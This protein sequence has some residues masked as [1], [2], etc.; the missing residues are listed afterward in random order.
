VKA[1]EKSLT[2]Y[3]SLVLA[4][5]KPSIRVCH[6][7][8]RV[9]ILSLVMVRPL[10]LVKHSYPLTSSIWSLTILQARSCPLEV[11][12]SPFEMLKMRPLRESAGI[13]CPAALLQGVRVGTLTSKREGA[14]TLY[15]SFLMK[16]WTL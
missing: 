13:T 9:H 16:G 8:T 5:M 15:H 1:I 7:L 11:V 10:K 14:R 3:P 6:F 2:R 4:W 12:K